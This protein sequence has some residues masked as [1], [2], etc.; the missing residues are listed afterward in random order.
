MEQYLSTKPTQ[1][2]IDVL[3]TV[4]KSTHF[5]FSRTRSSISHKKVQKY[6][7]SKKIKIKS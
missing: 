1:N 6:Q 7:R 2:Q 3:A 5:A 4:K